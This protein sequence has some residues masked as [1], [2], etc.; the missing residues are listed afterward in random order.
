MKT[1]K[2]I[3]TYIFKNPYCNTLYSF[4][5]LL[6]IMAYKIVYIILIEAYK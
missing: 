6:E 2:V 3:D 5:L 1:L 4:S